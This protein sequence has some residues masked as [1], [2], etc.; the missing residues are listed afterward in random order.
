M[1]TIKKI[2]SDHYTVFTSYASAR[3]FADATESYLLPQTQLEEG[4]SVRE[5]REVYVHD[6]ETNKI[7]SVNVG[8][9]SFFA[10]E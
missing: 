3:R 8:E 1:K 6:M 7:H 5:G 10:T 9:E 2:N 4:D